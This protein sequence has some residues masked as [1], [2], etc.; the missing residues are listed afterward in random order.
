MQINPDRHQSVYSFFKAPKMQL[1]SELRIFVVT[2]Y[3]RTRCFKD[4]QQLFEQRF[5]NRVSTT[6]LTIQKDVK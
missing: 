4:V 5:R 6:K 2:H 1:T 3:L